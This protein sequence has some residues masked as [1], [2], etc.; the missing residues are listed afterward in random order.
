MDNL[1][2]NQE[3]ASQETLIESQHFLPTS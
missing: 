1:L 2:K 3:I